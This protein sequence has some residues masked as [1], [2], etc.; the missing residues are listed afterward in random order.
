MTAQLMGS[1]TLPSVVDGSWLNRVDQ[2]WMSENTHDESGQNGELMTAKKKTTTDKTK[3]GG[4]RS[5]QDTG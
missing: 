1:V 3:A 5:M 4:T 2:F